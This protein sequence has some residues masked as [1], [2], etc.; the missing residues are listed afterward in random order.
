MASRTTRSAGRDRSSSTARTSRPAPN[1]QP[2]TPDRVTPPP[3][4]L[5]V[6]PTAADIDLIGYGAAAPGVPYGLV[7]IH[8]LKGTFTLATPHGLRTFE[9][10]DEAIVYADTEVAALMQMHALKARRERTYDQYLAWY[11]RDELYD[12]DDEAVGG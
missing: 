11:E 6:D 2:V 10:G 1:V 12:D 3:S 4:T 8:D 7:E 9:V 5:G